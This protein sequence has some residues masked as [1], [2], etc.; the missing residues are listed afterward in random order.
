MSLQRLFFPIFCVFLIFCSPEPQNEK[1]KI[2]SI[3]TQKI[4]ADMHI[5]DKIMDTALVD[6]DLNMKLLQPKLITADF[7]NKLWACTCPD[8]C[9][10]EHRE[11]SMPAIDSFCVYM[12]AASPEVQFDDRARY[13]GNRVTFIGR[14]YKEKSLPPAGYDPEPN[15]P[16]WYVFRYYG[17]TIH[18][19]FN[20]WGPETF[21]EKDSDIMPTVYS[22]DR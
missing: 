17:Y 1:E 4:L 19:P 10:W 9:Y 20:V 11:D 22:V 6:H 2:P 21:S 13:Y 15:M 16:E 7:T 8:W 12:E 5:T 18:K 14:I 3:D